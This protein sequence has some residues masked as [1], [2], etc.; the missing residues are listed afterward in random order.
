MSKSI[1]NFEGRFP[2]KCIDGKYHNL[3][4]KFKKLLEETTVLVRCLKCGRKEEIIFTKKDFD[5]SMP[6]TA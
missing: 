3:N 2:G 6:I 4:V 5:T 1:R